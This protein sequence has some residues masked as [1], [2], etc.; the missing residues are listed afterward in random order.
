MLMTRATESE[1]GA[2]E[3]VIFGGAGAVFKI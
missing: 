3:P 1:P 2:T